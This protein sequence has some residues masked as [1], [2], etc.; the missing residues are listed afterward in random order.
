MEHAPGPVVHVEPSGI[1]LELLAGETIIARVDPDRTTRLDVEHAVGVP[2][3]IELKLST[4]DEAGT[5]A[6]H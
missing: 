1:D 5:R 4:D 2:H 6:S 3:T